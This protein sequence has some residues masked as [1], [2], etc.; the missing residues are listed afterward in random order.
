MGCRARGLSF[1]KVIEQC[2]QRDRF[3][4]QLCSLLVGW[5]NYAVSLNLHNIIFAQLACPC[6]FVERMLMPSSRFSQIYK[7]ERYDF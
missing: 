2:L 6:Q 1:V 4:L 7:H 3:A 5:H